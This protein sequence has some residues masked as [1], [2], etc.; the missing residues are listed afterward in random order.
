MKN[1]ASPRQARDKRKW[2]DPTKENVSCSSAP[3]PSWWPTPTVVY[4]AGFVKLDGKRVVLLSNTNSSSQT[5]ALEGASGGVIHVVDLEHGHGD[6]PYRNESLES[7]TIQ[8][9]PLAVALIEM[10]PADQ[11]E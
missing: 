4:A 7:E 1:D 11:H 5:V 6:R 10:P 9:G 2:N 3:P 8:L